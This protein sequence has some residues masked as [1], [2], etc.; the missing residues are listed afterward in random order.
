[1]KFKDEDGNLVELEA[2][3]RIFLEEQE[4]LILAPFDNEDEEF[5]FRVDHDENG[6]EVYNAL[7]DDNEFLKVKKEYSRILYDDKET[8]DD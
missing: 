2:V 1:M 8:L 5:V 6:N 4:Y 3:A 7:D